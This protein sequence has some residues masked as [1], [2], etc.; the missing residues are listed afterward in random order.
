[1][2]IINTCFASSESELELSKFCKNMS[3][4]ESGDLNLSMIK[5]CCGDSCGSKPALSS[6]FKLGI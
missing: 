2:I 6:Y 1:M 4:V 5:V 3:M